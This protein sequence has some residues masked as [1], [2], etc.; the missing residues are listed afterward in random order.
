[1]PT[2]HVTAST[3]INRPLDEVRSVIADF[4]SWPAW[5][6]W[7]RM[8]PNAPVDYYGEAGQ[9]G[10]GYRWEGRKVGAGEMV[11]RELTDK[12]LL[13]DLTFIKPFTSKADVGFNLTDHG[14][15]TEVEWLMDSSLPFF[16]FFW[17][18]SMKG[19]ITMDYSRGLALLKDHIE[20][21]EIACHVEP[22]GVVNIPTCS[23]LGVTEKV[24]MSEIGTSMQNSFNEVKAALANTDTSSQG[25]P[26][27]VYHKMDVANGVCHYTAAVPV[28]KDDANKTGILEPGEIPSGQAFKVVFT[29][30]YR[31]I[32]NAWAM[33]VSEMRL[34]NLKASKRDK[35]FEHYI[36]DPTRTPEN[37]LV[38]EIFIPLR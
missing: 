10:H 12:Q 38:T 13:A 33:A 14:D 9:V 27:S 5:S 6:P 2:F 1:M 20:Q 22:I 8:E 32:G 15:S 17:V 26:M 7:L 19:M 16:M 29:G 37:D 23:Y 4:N 35:P 18:K 24:R 28:H 36:S 11:W 34:L 30:P 21:G 31:H 25:V 3:R